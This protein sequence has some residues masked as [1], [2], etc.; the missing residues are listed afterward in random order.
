MHTGSSS[1]FAVSCENWITR[2]D[3]D[4]PNACEVHS[5]HRFDIVH[6]VYLL[7]ATTV[8]YVVQF[9]AVGLLTLLNFT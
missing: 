7:S 3:T 4:P 5:S 8:A 9:V 6:K 1:S 2:A